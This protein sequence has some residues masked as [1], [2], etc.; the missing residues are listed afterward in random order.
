[1]KILQLGILFTAI[2]VL[3]CVAVPQEL[4]WKDMADLPRPVAGYMAASS[5][6]RLL[7]IGGSYW[8]NEKKYWVDRV[9]TF[10]P[11]DNTWRNEAPLPAPRSDAALAVLKN[12][13]YILGG[14]SSNE[15]T[16]D[17]LV[18]QHNKWQSLPAAALSAPRK[19]PVAVAA[20]KYIYLLG[21]MSKDNDYTSV[22]N[23]FWRWRPG[24][25]Q[26]EVLPPLPGPGRINAAMTQ[27]GNSIYVFGGATSAPSNDVANL[28]DVYKFNLASQT[29]SRLPDLPLANRAWWAVSLGSRALLLG[30][31]TD[32]FARE[33]AL[34]DPRKTSFQPATSLPHGVADMRFVRLG[35]LVIGTGGEVGEH[36]RGKWTMQAELPTAW[37][38]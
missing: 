9:Q 24:L 15:I 37:T 31:Y 3:N 33:V 36:I 6:G 14:G 21:G 22:T 30:G 25:N 16:T 35:N 11:Q 23:T 34:Y 12:K 5:H 27:V 19:Y 7:V 18:L 20:G 29:W 4:A 38:K 10:D 17:A 13:I 26:W 1:V 2:H 28:K 8:E 32:T